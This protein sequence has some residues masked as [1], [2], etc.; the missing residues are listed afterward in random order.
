MLRTTFAFN[1][2]E[3]STTDPQNEAGQEMYLDGKWYKWVQNKTGG[4]TA[5]GDV[6][7]Y[8][9]AQDATLKKVYAPATAILN[10]CAGVWLT[11]CAADSYGWIQTAGVNNSV[12]EMG[13]A[14]TA[15]GDNLIP[16]NGQTYFSRGTATGT[17][18]TYPK[19]AVEMEAYTTT[20]AA[21]KKVYLTCRV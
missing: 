14:S 20:S 6:S 15:K 8:D 19:G 11:V 3:T 1:L 2:T 10:F 4:A 16:T 5:I 12:N 18:P 9:P 17:A 21:L 7:C 13:N